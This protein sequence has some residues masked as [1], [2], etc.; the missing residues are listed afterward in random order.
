MMSKWFKIYLRNYIRSPKFLLSIILILSVTATYI[1]MD[2]GDST[3]RVGIVDESNG[4]YGERLLDDLTELDSIFEFTRVEDLTSLRSGLESGNYILGYKIKDSLDSKFEKGNFNNLI[5]V[6]APDNSLMVNLTNE[7]VYAQLFRQY[8]FDY[9]TKMLLDYDENIF[10]NTSV[11]ELE[12][13]YDKYIDSDYT[14]KFQGAPEKINRSFYSR[15]IPIDK[16]FAFIVFVMGSLSLLEVYEFRKTQLA[17]NSSKGQ[18]TVMENYIVAS[19]VLT[20]GIM[21]L[22]IEAFILPSGIDLNRILVFANYSISILLIIN[23]YG[24]IFRRAENY[25]VY[26]PVIIIASL[27]IP[28]VI[29]DVERYFSGFEI[30]RYLF[31]PHYFIL[32]SHFKLIGNL[33]A[34]MILSMLVGF[35]Y[36]MLSLG[37]NKS[38]SNYVSESEKNI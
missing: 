18:R 38:V 34:F 23:V 37:I 20:T 32:F 6:Y 12:I 3:M 21:A 19:Y 31:G 10:Y 1:V 27:L 33:L 9:M 17:L 28:N 36:K 5:E 4:E 14:Y 7:I 2:R 22:A 11:D 25:V 26:L 8:S 13:K 30:F 16:V 15:I 24:L 35:A 29:V